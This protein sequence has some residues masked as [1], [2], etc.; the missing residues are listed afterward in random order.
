MCIRASARPAWRVVNRTFL[1]FSRVFGVF[2]AMSLEE[3]NVLNETV[4]RR[5]I[6]VGYAMGCLAMTGAVVFEGDRV[7]PVVPA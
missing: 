1:R 3:R 4:L 2:G 5:V 7:G 6:A